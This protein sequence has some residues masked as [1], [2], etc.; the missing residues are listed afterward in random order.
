MFK[1]LELH[2]SEIEVLEQRSITHN[3]ALLESITLIVDLPLDC[4]L[5]G[6]NPLLVKLAQIHVARVPGQICEVDRSIGVL[7]GHVDARVVLTQGGAF[8]QLD[9]FGKLVHFTVG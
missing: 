3:T 1:L 7:S 6:A 8:G 2:E 9:K 4:D 5:T